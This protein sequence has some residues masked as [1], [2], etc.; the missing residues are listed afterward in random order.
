[1]S[2]DEKDVAMRALFG[3]VPRPPLGDEAFVRSVM[4]GVERDKSARAVSRNAAAIGGTALL[5]AMLWPV[6]E[7]LGLAFVA[8]LEQGAANLPTVSAGALSLII[9]AVVSAAAWVY[10]ERG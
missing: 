8:G 3:D 10:A 5:G 9:A 4:T 6:R 1:M 7:P 2:E